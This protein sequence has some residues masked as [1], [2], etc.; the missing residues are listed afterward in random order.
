[1]EVMTGVI[2]LTANET[3]HVRRVCPVVLQEPEKVQTNTCEG[4][5]SSAPV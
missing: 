2:K 5:G 4:S 1:M 3:E